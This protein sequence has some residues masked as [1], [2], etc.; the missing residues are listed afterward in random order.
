MLQLSWRPRHV[1]LVSDPQQL[2]GMLHKKQSTVCIVIIYVY[3]NS[4]RDTQFVYSIVSLLCQNFSTTVSVV[5]WPIIWL[6][7][8]LQYCTCRDIPRILYEHSELYYYIIYLPITL[9]GTSCDGYSSLCLN[10]LVP[11]EARYIWLG[12]IIVYTCVTQCA[13]FEWIDPHY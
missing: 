3:N 4:Y 2:S 7:P 6:I 10:L 13:Q 11:T 5:S 8:C 12:H 9:I 1:E